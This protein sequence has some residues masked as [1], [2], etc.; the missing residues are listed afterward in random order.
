M[1]KALK[2]TLRGLLGSPAY[3]A[4]GEFVQELRIR[5]IKTH[6]D[7][8]IENL[9]RPYMPKQGFYLDVG[10]HDGRS[11]SNTFHLEAQGWTG[12]LI[13]PVPMKYFK[14]LKTRSPRR[15][16]FVNSACVSSHFNAHHLEMIY[17][18]LMSFAPSISTL[19]SKDWISGSRQFMS[20][21]EEQI[22]IWVKAQTLDKILLECSAPTDIDFL[23]I[24]VEGAE[25]DVLDGLDLLKFNF[26]VVCIETRNKDEV[27]AYFRY[28]GY[29]EIGYVNGNLLFHNPK[30][31]AV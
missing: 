3:I 24:D 9:V 14:M 27:R 8:M 6:M 26:K 1:A 21:F 22:Q 29:L 23:S 20:P 19:D 12:I 13:E 31:L 30:F 7:P 28:L 11:F 16:K 25:L 17:C 4:L 18:D 5:R 15:N 10:A 2:R